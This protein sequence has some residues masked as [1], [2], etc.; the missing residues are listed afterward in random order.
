V[1]AAPKPCV[2]LFRGIN[3]GRAKRVA[4]ADLK[5]MFEGLGCI[6]VKT[7]L[8]SGNV[9]FTPPPDSD[10][11]FASMIE[12]ELERTAGFGARVT[13]LSAPELAEVFAQN[14]MVELAVNPSRLLVA[15]LNDRADLALLE[16]LQK[17][18]WS[19]DELALGS[20]AA[21]LWCP[22]GVL[23]S[24]LPDAVGRLVGDRVTTRNWATLK[25]LVGMF[26]RSFS[27]SEHSL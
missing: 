14:P 11:S 22:E 19:P 13:V 3:V 12:D 23:A 5:S 24:R 21:Y 20:R 15:I 27:A 26:Q 8:A 6:E 25:K 17:D 10:G 1:N 18:D 9:V 16:P 4:M 7:V 2:A